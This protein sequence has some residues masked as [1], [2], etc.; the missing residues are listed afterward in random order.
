MTCQTM[1]T[2]S[3]YLPD[4]VKAGL[5]RVAASTGK[6]RNRLVVEACEALLRQAGGSFPPGFFDNGHLSARDLAEMR[7]GAEDMSRVIG[8]S[9][10]NRRSAPF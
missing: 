7:R 5:D 1:A 10:R 6:T 8:A 9:R 4:R 2:T 3:V